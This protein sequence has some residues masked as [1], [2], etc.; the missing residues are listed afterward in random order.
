MSHLY[1]VSAAMGAAAVIA[2]R[3]FL[4]NPSHEKQEE[5]EAGGE[6]EE[7]GEENGHG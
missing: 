1:I 5:P 2:W 6:P 3:V 4:V 7:K